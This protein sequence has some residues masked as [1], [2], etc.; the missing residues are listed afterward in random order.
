M[1]VRLQ[2]F[3]ADAGVASRRASETI[4]SEGRV[5]VNGEVV[6]ELGSKVDPSQDRVSVDGRPIKDKRKLYV[7]LNKPRGY[8]S[9]RSDPE[10]R[11]LVGELLPKEWA[12]LYPVG[13]LDYNS[14]GLIFL[15]NDGE[16]ALRLTHPRYGVPKKYRVT[17]EGR[18]EPAK[19]EQMTR[20][21][22]HQG[23]KLK[24]NRFWLVSSSNRRTVFDLELTEGKNR[25]VRRLCE[26][27]H[28]SV[29]RLE[30]T[31]IGRIKLGQLPSGKWRV[32][33]EPEIRSLKDAA[34]PSVA[35]PARRGAR[36]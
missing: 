5:S 12:N 7:A 11:R 17:V 14:E 33:S 25:E 36:R 26:S 23:E 29:E 35:S 15:T 1:V 3:L 32:L 13:R 9:S 28:L 27:Q 2:K 10:G 18:V 6:R 22:F 31:Q 16:L 21:V 34:K 24:A 20:G 30:R 4:I 8:I 19:L